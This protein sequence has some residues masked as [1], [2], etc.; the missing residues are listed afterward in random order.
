MLVLTRQQ[1]EALLIGDEVEVVIT[2]F[3]AL[4][5]GHWVDVTPDEPIQVKIGIK[6]PRSVVILR[7]EVEARQNFGNQKPK[8]K[9]DSRPDNVGN[10]KKGRDFGGAGDW[11]K[12]RRSSQR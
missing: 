9:K 12:R 2:G 6:A 4:R 7:K 5:N 11:R 1:E 10:R 3:Q 8:P